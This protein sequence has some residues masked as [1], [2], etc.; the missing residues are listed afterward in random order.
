MARETITAGKVLVNGVDLTDHITSVT[1][2]DTAEEIETTNLGTE[3]YRTYI[4]GLKTA[5]VTATFQNDHATGSVA[6]TL[7]PLYASSSIF[8]V[9]VWPKASGTVVYTLGSAQLFS[10]P[11]M[12]GGVGDLSTVDVTFNNAGATGTTRGTA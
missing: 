10:K 11:M 7:Q 1:L 2:E 12:G 8:P 5:N 3:G 6:D 4:Q 9:K